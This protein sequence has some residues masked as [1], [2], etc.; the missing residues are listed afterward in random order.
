VAKKIDTLIRAWR[1][2]QAAEISA[3]DALD[4]AARA[5]AETVELEAE[6]SLSAGRA[7]LAEA[8]GLLKKAEEL[9]ATL[10]AASRAQDE[11]AAELSA[12]EDAA[13]DAAEA[14]RRA[15]PAGHVLVR[16]VA[17]HIVEDEHRKNPE[18]ATIFGAGET[19][20]L[21]EASAQHFIVRGK[22]EAVEG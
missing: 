17:E 5:M 4:A 6:A 7:S 11:A 18:R 10:A 19:H 21:P 22:A 13:R 1:K 20:A 9:R 8:P 12:A 16:F 14:V 2:A 15:I 3:R